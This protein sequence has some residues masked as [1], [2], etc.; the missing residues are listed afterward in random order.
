[1]VTESSASG[2]SATW[3]VIP[4]F[5]EART[6]GPIV[7]ECQAFGAGPIVVD[8]GSSDD[9]AN[10]AEASG[11]LVLR[12]AGNQGKGA[13]LWRGMQAAVAAGA[14]RV[15][16]LDADGQHRPQDI[17]LLLSRRPSSEEPA[18]IVIGSR[19]AGGRAASRSRAAPRARYLANRVADFWVSWAA[20]HPVEDSQ[21]GFRVYPAELL[22]RLAARPPMVRGFAFESEILIEAGR[23]G[24]RTVAVDIPSIY[25]AMQRPSHFRPVADIARIVLMVAGKLLRGGMD[26][27][28]LWRSLGRPLGRPQGR[29]P[30]RSDPRRAMRSRH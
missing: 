29:S 22:R 21:S 26:P 24:V 18:R 11:A 7:R 1:V 6:I 2:E 12:N 13:S 14:S 25:S 16:T 5:N 27:L 28:G 19:R 10:I 30:N 4:A 8:D 23:L 15:V 3:I 9:T 20:R 17:P